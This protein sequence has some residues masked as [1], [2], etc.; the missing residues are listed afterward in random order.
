MSKFTDALSAFLDGEPYD[1]IRISVCDKDG[2]IETLER[3][4]LA[5]CQNTYSVAK[6]FTMTAIGLLYDKGL[7]KPEDKI[8]DILKDEITYDIP[9][10]SWYSV[11]V[12]HALTHSAGLPGGFLDIDVHNSTEFTTDFLRYMLMTQ[13]EY[14]PGTESRYSDGA[15]YL[16]ARVAEKLSGMPMDDFLWKELFV[17]LGFREAAWSHCPMGHA[18]G[19]TGFYANSADMVKLGYV[20]LNG[21]MYRGRRI[22]SEE[23]INLA[24]EKEYGCGWDNGREC[25]SKGG[26]NG[27]TITMVPSTKTAFMIQ[28]YGADCGRISRFILDY[29]E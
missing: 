14:E 29:K 19:A 28:S 7:V 26:M 10:K 11:T 20:Y 13:L 25:Y 24:T 2:K 1:A 9:D 3:T 12:E 22:L 16:L 4:E 27:Q 17:K 6:F 8:C 18:M 21:G 15:F 5:Y 23:W